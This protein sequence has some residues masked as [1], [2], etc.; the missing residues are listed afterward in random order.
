[1]GVPTEQYVDDL[2]VKPWSQR[3][4]DKLLW[5]GS[6]TGAWYDVSTTWR[7]SHRVRLLRLAN[8]DEVDGEEEPDRITL[9]P[10]PKRLKGETLSRLSETIPWGKVNG[11]YMNVAFT[12]N[13]IRELC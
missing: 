9:L 5:R 10:A 11:H 13:P 6:N 2:D 3:T 1:M 8:L 12:E 7:N 4:E